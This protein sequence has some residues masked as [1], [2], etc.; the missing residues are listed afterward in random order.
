MNPLLIK[1]IDFDPDFEPLVAGSLVVPERV[2]LAIEK[3]RI[4]LRRAQEEAL[5]I[6]ARAQE[7][8]AS[9]ETER[10]EERQRG[11]EDGHEEAIAEYAER[12]IQASRAEERVMTE[13]EPQ[14]VKMVMDIAEKVIGRE[15]EKGA[16]VDVVRKTIQDAVGKKVTVRVHPDDYVVLKEKESQ[17][18]SVLDQTRS[19]SV[20]EDESIER[21]GCIVE[22]ELGVVDARLSTQL[23]AIRKALGLEEAP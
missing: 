1:K 3:E 5:Q 13:S 17:L 2:L 9:A 21:G 20:R 4:I 6:K 14:L 16:V 22:T 11:Y 10:E 12:M 8:L 23:S 7:I 18:F 15:L 19:I